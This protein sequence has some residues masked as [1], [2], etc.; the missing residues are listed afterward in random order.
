M[1]CFQLPVCSELSSM[2][3]KFDKQFV[4]LCR[5]LDSTRHFVSTVNI[6][7]LPTF[8]NNELLI[9]YL[10][11]T[12]WHSVLLYAYC[13]VHLVYLVKCPQCCT[14][15]YCTKN[16]MFKTVF[17]VFTVDRVGTM[18]CSL[19][20]KLNRDVHVRSP[21]TPPFLASLQ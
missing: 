7:R 3:P 9:L 12:V 4:T 6:A 17:T 21:H 19:L 10:Y 18:I 11:C 8:C 15:Q 2:L 14:V 20:L 16:D 13:T 5:M 1:Y